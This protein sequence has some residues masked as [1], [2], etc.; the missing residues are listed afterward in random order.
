[1]PDYRRIYTPGGTYFFT[2]NLLN[3]KQKLLTENYELLMTCFDEAAV[4]HPFKMPYYVVL[5]DHLHCIWRLPEED[6]DF[7]RRWQIIKSRFSRHIPKSIDLS[8]GRRNGER[9]IWQRRFWEHLIR[10][11]E[12]MG[13]HIDYIHNNP[14]KHGYTDHPKDWAFSSWHDHNES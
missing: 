1:M 10:D 14:I 13:N 4:S 9:G 5:P 3:R 6:S 11:A 8:P 7:S 12:D 2:V